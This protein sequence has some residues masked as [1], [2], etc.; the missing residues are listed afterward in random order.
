MQNIHT[1]TGVKLADAAKEFKKMFSC[2]ASVVKTPSGKEQI[3]IQVCFTELFHLKRI[4]TCT[5]FS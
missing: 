4:K 5:Q 1:G 3:D 2:G